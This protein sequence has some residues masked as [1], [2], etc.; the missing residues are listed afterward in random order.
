MQRATDQLTQIDIQLIDY[1]PPA[2]L[3]RGRTGH[4]AKFDSPVSCFVC[5][6]VV[7]DDGLGVAIASRL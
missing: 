7:G 5:G 2:Y 6:R 3:F 4:D 1:G